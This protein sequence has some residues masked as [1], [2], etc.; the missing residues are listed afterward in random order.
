[1]K[2]SG[3][4]GGFYVVASIDAVAIYESM[5]EVNAH[6]GYFQHPQISDYNNIV[7]AEF[8]AQVRLKDI[9]PEHVATPKYMLPGVIYYRDHPFWTR[10]RRRHH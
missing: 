6:R 8:L 10:T 9:L 7:L 5:D 1:M 2:K 4:K 3:E